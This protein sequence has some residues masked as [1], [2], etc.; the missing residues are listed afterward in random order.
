LRLNR[1]T[2]RSALKLDGI[3][4][5]REIMNTENVLLTIGGAGLIVMIIVGLNV[6]P[7]P[8]VQQPATAIPVPANGRC[9]AATMEEAAADLGMPSPIQHPTD[10]RVSAVRLMEYLNNPLTMQQLMHRHPDLCEGLHGY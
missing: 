2:G 9:A 8:V 5:E 1:I 4:I 7:A 10:A 3:R 6:N